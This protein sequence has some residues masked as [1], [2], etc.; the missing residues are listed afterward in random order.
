MAINLLIN[1]T[2]S[3]DGNW[4]RV[5]PPARRTWPFSAKFISGGTA[6]SAGNVILEELVGGVP[7]S[8]GPITQYNPGKLTDNVQTGT[9]VQIGVFGPG[10]ADFEIDWP[11]DFIRARTDSGITG[12]VSVYLQEAA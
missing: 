3:I 1:A 9:I 2:A 7:T 11:I 5:E 12:N 4:V 10:V 6:W 8:P